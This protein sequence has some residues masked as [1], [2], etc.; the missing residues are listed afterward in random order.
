MIVAP[1]AGVVGDGSLQLGFGVMAAGILVA[2]GAAYL[3]WR[4]A[5][6]HEVALRTEA[7]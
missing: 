2:A 7:G 6:A 5:D 4:R 1:V 3:A